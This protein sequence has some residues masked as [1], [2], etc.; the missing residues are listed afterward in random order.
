MIDWSYYK[1]FHFQYGKHIGNKLYLHRSLVGTLP[2][3][4]YNE[5]MRLDEEFFK[6]MR[7][8]NPKFK[9]YNIIKIDFSTNTVSFILSKRFDTDDEPK[10]DM[11]YVL[12]NDETFYIRL[13]IDYRGKKSVPIYHH[14]W[15]MVSYR[16]K[17][18]DVEASTAR[19]KWWENHPFIKHMMKKDKYFKSHIGYSKYWEEVLHFM[20]ICEVDGVDE[21]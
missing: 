9:G 13:I 14:K 2:E 19:S 1:T 3:K 10:I 21:I 15:M 20:E 8:D 17:G 12:S 16:Y 4:M 11:V 6:Y 18:F 5:L 7:K